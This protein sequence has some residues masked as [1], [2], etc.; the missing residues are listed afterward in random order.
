MKTAKE[1]ATVSMV[2][3]L[4]SL[5]DL[6]KPLVCMVSGAAFGIACTMTGLADFIYCTPDATFNTPFM[7]SFQ[8]PEGGSTILFPA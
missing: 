2:K 1:G 3:V 4:T 6:E 5:L 7:S 8:S